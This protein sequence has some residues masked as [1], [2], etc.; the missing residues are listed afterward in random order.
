LSPVH[1]ERGTQALGT[2]HKKVE[3]KV[4]QSDRLYVLDVLNY[5]M[6]DIFTAMGIDTSGGRF[7][8]PEEKEVDMNTKMAI[9]TQLKTNYNL[10]IDDDYLYE[11]FGI[12]KPKDYDQK[13][14]EQQ[15]QRE[16]QRQLAA[17]AL[18]TQQQDDEQQD[19]EQQE[20]QQEQKK[21]KLA[22]RVRS[23]F[24]KAPQDGADLDW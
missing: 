20:D 6:A 21:Q 11:E 8:F 17:Q 12:P 10:P 2:V 7:C 9:L 22:S 14:K 13:K 18:Q 19:D 4:A 1:C 24:A 15:E 23:F 5:D 16:R 3:D